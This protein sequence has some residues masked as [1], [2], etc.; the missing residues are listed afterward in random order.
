VPRSVGR[1]RRHVLPGR[2]SGRRGLRSR[3]FGGEKKSEFGSGLR[4]RGRYLA[5]FTR[6]FRS[7]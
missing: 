6:R 3:R 1:G 7:R 4:Y 2:R 5:A